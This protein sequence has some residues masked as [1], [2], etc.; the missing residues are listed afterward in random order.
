[1]KKYTFMPHSPVFT[2]FSFFMVLWV[3]IY[4]PGSSH[5][6]LMVD[7]T[8]GNVNPLPMAIVDF[9]GALPNKDTSQKIGKDI[10]T[11]VGLDLKSS[12]LFHLVNHEAFITKTIGVDHLPRFA[13]WRLIKADI[14]VTG[15]VAVL[16]DNKIELK[17][18]LW[19][20]LEGK[21]IFALKMTTQ[22]KHWR[23]LAHLAA[24]AIYKNLTG[25][26]GY[27]DTRIVYVAETGPKN[28]R[29]KR[30]AVVDQDGHGTSYLTDGAHLVL[31]PRF[32]PTTSNIVYL[33]YYLKVPRVYVLSIT[34]GKQEIL[35][36]FPDMTFAPRFSPD[37][38]NVI[39]SL[40]R[41]G[42][43][44]IYTLNLRT[45]ITRALTRTNAIDTAPSY[46]PD[47]KYITFESDRSG[48]QQIY[49]MNTKTGSTKRISFGEGSYATPVWS[50][51][52]DFIAFTKQYRGRFLIGVMHPDGRGERI[53]TQ[54][55]HNEGPTWAPNGRVLMF[56][57]EDKQGKG[58]SL[59]KVDITGYNERLFQTPT[60]ASDPAW[61]P[62]LGN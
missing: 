28:R 37:G 53:L 56:F 25:E 44:D 7:I 6:A 57:R 23:R 3:G 45:R 10:A 62:R 29:I 15:T 27:F 20:V 36:D 17:I 39:M 58:A 24:D 41:G 2:A 11:V 26:E 12:G 46:S 9:Q 13:D 60:K 19:N 32:D 38:K 61:S 4:L 34:T 40:Q 50:P 49:V 21:Q 51:R 8:Q 33:S 14:L 30:L 43:S 48:K 42:A 1:M 54:G 52:G 16:Q 5:G 35:G 22:R 47:G 59:W 31:T 55:Y 18:R